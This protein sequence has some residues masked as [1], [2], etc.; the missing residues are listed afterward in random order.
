[1][2]SFKFRLDFCVADKC[3]FWKKWAVSHLFCN[4]E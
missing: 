4:L 2:E 1:M 3:P